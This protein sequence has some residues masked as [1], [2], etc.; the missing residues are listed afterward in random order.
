MDVL[1]AFG[2]GLA[3][4]IATGFGVFPVY[5]ASL[6]D[7]G[8][9]LLW[10]VSA[11]VMATISV[12]ELLFPGLEAPRYLAGGTLAGIAFVLA[13]T[14]WLHHGH[15]AA[16]GD[17][18][19]AS[20]AH[21]LGGSHVSSLSLLLFLVFTVHSA[22]EGVGIGSALREGQATGLAVVVAIA[23]H[24]IPEGTAVAV[25]LRAD[26][27]SL[28]RSFG[29]AIVTSLPQPLLAPLVFLVAVGRWLP[30]GMG[31]AG[32]AML[33]LVVLE[34]VPEGWREDAGGFILGVLLGVGVGVGL[35]LL[36]GTPA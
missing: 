26:G 29:W 31:F 27:V 28:W 15:G 33:A 7:R 6:G 23:I 3:T 1:Q 14:R 10:G 4:A 20:A 16:E 9:G 12:L 19:T 35:N 2:L 17:A 34:V 24:N 18:D 11:G 21:H 36:L 8:L 5:L 25:G 32:G 13:S 30:A 22:P